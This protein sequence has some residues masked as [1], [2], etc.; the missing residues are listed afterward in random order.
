MEAFLAVETLV[1]ELLLVATLV[2]IGVR[3]LRV[4]NTVALVVVG[5]LITIGRKIQIALS[6]ELVLALFVPPLVFEAAFHLRVR[7]VREN[8]VPM[9]VLAVPGVILTTV[10]VGVRISWATPIS[11]GAAI[12]FGA[13]I[14][15]TDPVAGVALFRSIG[16]P[17]RLKVLIESE[18]LFNDGTEIVV[19]TVALTA[20]LSGHFDPMAGTIEPL[21]VALGGTIV[22][23]GL[24]AIAAWIIGRVD[25]YLIETTLTT[26]LAFGSYLV[27]ERFHFSGVLA[28]VMAGIVC[29]NAGPK[30]MSPTTRIVLFNFWE[31]AA[32]LANSLVFLLIGL[33]VSIPALI[34]SWQ[35][36]LMAVLSVFAARAL[37]VYGLGWVVERL[38]HGIPLSYLHAMVWSGLRGAISLGLALS[39][40]LDLGPDRELIR[41]M[42]LR[43]CSSR[44]WDRAPPFAL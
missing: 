8:L 21:D 1:I 9:L 35:T 25:D 36:V 27:A 5:L 44:Y 23:L 16:A 12:V 13:L 26:A 6:P 39:L 24:G 31:Y 43:L 11:M 22:G 3:R 10:I 19:Y 37:V 18:S 15:A 41:V 34:E 42:R 20:A 2:A 14:A 7:E 29:G 38:R 40:P 4:P 33:D 32:F 30:G 17:Q 28:V